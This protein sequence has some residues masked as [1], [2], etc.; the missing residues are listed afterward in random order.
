MSPQATI[1][2]GKPSTSGTRYSRLGMVRPAT[3]HHPRWCSYHH[4]GFNR[5]LW[6]GVDTRYLMAQ[7]VFSCCRIDRA[8]HHC[9]R[10]QTGS[11]ECSFGTRFIS[12][13][14]TSRC[15]SYCL[16]RTRI[17]G[18]CE[19]LVLCFYLLGL[20]IGLS[21]ASRD[22]CRHPPSAAFSRPAPSPTHLQRLTQFVFSVPW[23]L[24]DGQSRATWASCRP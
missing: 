14:G 6:S 12:R 17:R 5:Y 10:P 3:S 4:H 15:R 7:N 9:G 1:R 22:V 24:D 2:I 19:F 8:V 20:R 16:G 13:V 21:G 18:L 23:R 11:S